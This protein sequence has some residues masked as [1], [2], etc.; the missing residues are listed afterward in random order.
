MGP[1][2]ALS[3]EHMNWWH[4]LWA[5]P[6]VFFFVLFKQVREFFIEKIWKRVFGGKAEALATH[7]FVSALRNHED[8]DNRRF[9]D[10]KGYIGDVK[11]DIVQSLAQN[12][13]YLRED[14]KVERQSTEKRMEFLEKVF[15]DSRLKM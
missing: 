6:S 12:I 5:S 10:I 9:N 14:I 8:D 2:Q 11:A 3:P 4:M 7:P 15:L 13:G 1:E